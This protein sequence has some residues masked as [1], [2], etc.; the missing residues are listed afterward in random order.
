MGER[1]ELHQEEEKLEIEYRPLKKLVIL[2]SVEMPQKD[3]FERLVAQIKLSGQP[4][5][6]HWAEGIVFLALPLDAQSDLIIDEMLTGT[7][8]WA[9][10]SYAKMPSYQPI[11]KIGG[12][13]IPIINQSHSPKMR[14]IAGWLKK[15]SGNK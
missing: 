9:S 2:E 1:P 6:L 15:R 8:Y 11:A 13:E 3:L 4:V 10:V 12:V 14:Q 5:A 7:A